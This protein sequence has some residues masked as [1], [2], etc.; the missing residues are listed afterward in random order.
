MKDG[1]PIRRREKQLT[2]PLPNGRNIPKIM[3]SKSGVGKGLKKIFHGR[4]RCVCRA[5][6]ANMI[7]RPPKA[8]PG[9]AF[10]PR[11][12]PRGV[13]ISGAT[14]H[15]TYGPDGKFRSL[16]ARHPRCSGTRL[17]SAG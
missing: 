10:T 1:K 13:E 12:K 17:A 14:A 11:S 15:S 2:R 7:V 8:N 5:L 16:S 9:P 3:A 6:I 4:E